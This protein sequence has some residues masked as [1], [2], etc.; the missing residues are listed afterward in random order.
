MAKFFVGQKVRILWSHGWPELAGQEGRIVGT[1]VYHPRSPH[2]GK[3]CWLVAPDS[4]GSCT[5]PKISS[6]GGNE[7]GAMDTQ[8]EPIIPEGMKPVEWEDCEW[9]P[10]EIKEL[11]VTR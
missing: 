3:Q 9:Q 5:A 4:W 11:V 7:F 6:N 1:G 10:D 2:A 8:L